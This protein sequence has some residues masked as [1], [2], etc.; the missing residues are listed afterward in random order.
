MRKGLSPLISRTSAI[1]SKSR[2]TS[3]FF[4]TPGGGAW[5]VP[6]RT[7]NRFR[8]LARSRSR[9]R[10]E[11][12]P[13]WG[14]DSSPSRGVRRARPRASG[15]H[16]W[17][18]PCTALALDVAYPIARLGS[19]LRACVVVVLLALLVAGP[20]LADEISGQVRDAVTGKSIAGA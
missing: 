11:R 8:A 4:M 16:G 17:Q 2:A 3:K 13:P 15:G 7:A 12:V 10:C 20:A 18:T 5:P 1:R 19:A 14:G 9:R 6:R